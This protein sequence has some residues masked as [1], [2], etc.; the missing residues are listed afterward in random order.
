VP[1]Y[2]R[3]VPPGQGRPT[4]IKSALMLMRR[5]LVLPEPRPTGSNKDAAIF[6][7]LGYKQAL[8]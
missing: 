6:E 8:P 7:K 2:H 3:A 5:S 1:G 4:A